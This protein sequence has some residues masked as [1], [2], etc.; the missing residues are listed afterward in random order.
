MIRRADS[1]RMRRWALLRPR[2]AAKRP[3]RDEI[4]PMHGRIGRDGPDFLTGGGE[5][6]ARM[7]AHDWSLSPL[8]PPATW[9]QSLRTVV[10]LLLT[11]RFPMFMAWGPELGF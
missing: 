9:P 5:M 4:V 1:A 8:G 7:R 3:I 10:S 6:G 2:D 11:S